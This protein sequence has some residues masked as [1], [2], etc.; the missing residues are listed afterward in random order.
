MRWPSGSVLSSTIALVDTA[1]TGATRPP[2]RRAAR[3][4]ISQFAP[5][6][7]SAAVTPI[8]STA[9]RPTCSPEGPTAASRPLPSGPPEKAAIRPA[10]RPAAVPAAKPH[11]GAASSIGVGAIRTVTMPPNTPAT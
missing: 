1:G 4:R 5:P 8:S 9:T 10:S 2:A 7:A 3:D 6:A 11:S